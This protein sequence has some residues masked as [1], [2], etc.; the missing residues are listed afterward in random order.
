[1]RKFPDPSE[2]KKHFDA[3][4]EDQSIFVP[5][6]RPDKGVSIVDSPAEV[7]A[8]VET[9]ISEGPVS[10]YRL[11]NAATVY[12]DPIAR[13]QE[14]IR[15]YRA[16]GGTAEEFKGRIQ[17]LEDEI[18]YQIL[19]EPMSA[20]QKVDSLVKLS[21]LVFEAQKRIEDLIHRDRQEERKREEQL[22]RTTRLA[23]QMRAARARQEG[24]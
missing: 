24:K 7:R 17:S 5:P 3:Q 19:F 9:E 12:S 1:M 20:K 6:R 21:K 15:F 4:R 11:R 18:L 2:V 14:L 8:V 23:E 16:E 10:L 13:T 22:V